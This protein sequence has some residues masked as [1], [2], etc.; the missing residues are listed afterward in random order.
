MI[1]TILQA[2]L[3]TLA[4]KIFHALV[5]YLAVTALPPFHPFAFAAPPLALAG[6][7]V[8]YDGYVDI[9]TQNHIIDDALMKPVLG[10]ILETVTTSHTDSLSGSVNATQNH[11]DSAALTNIEARQLP[12]T[13]LIPLIGVIIST[14]TL[15]FASIVWIAQDDP[16]RTNDVE[17][18]IEHSD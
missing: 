4:M 11:N 12:A 17:Y 6:I 16:V 9:S 13:I 14:V 5:G 15:V 1:R 18:L 3:N 2:D 10:N 7:Q 8:Y